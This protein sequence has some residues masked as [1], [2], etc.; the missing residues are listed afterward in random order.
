VRK[1]F[2]Q[3]DANLKAIDFD[4]RNAYDI[5]EEQKAQMPEGSEW[6]LRQLVTLAS[7]IEEEASIP[8][9]YQASV[10][11]VFWNRLTKPLPSDLPRR[12]MGSDVTLRYLTDWVARDYGGLD[13]TDMSQPEM[14][15]AALAIIP[16]DIFYG[17]YTGDDDALTQE[18][19]PISPISNPGV[20]ALVAALQPEL[21]N[22]FYF[23][24][25]KNGEYRFAERYWQHQQNITE[26]VNANA[27][28]EAE[29][30]AGGSSEG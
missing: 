12:T 19:L 18:G 9:Q 25:F 6:G 26:M 3:F 7:I 17:Y 1:L 22:Y 11:G 4:G 2:Q 16:Q 30:A 10:S 29:Q 27:A 21:H 20:S 15:A 23:L 24:A 14:K 28:W 5:I 13:V 8:D